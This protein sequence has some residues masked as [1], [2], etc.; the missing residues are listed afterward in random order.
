MK[1]T[2]QLV[3][4]SEAW[5]QFRLDHFGASEAAAMLSLSKNVRRNDLLRMKKTGLAKVF[6]DWVQKNVLDYGHKVEKLA[7][8]LIEKRIGQDLYPVTCSIGKI[9]ASCDGLTLDDEIA[10]E[11]KQWNEAY[12]ALI[13]AGEVPEEHMPQ[14]Q[15]ILM[16]TGA[17]K[18][19]LVMSDG[20]EEN[21]VSIE[22][23]PDPAW[24]DRLRAGWDQFEVD[25]ADYVPESPTAEPV[26]RTPESLP[27]LR[28]EVTGMVT[29]SN[30]L[31][32]KEHAFAV[33]AGINRELT[34]DQH[35]ADAAKTVKWCGDVEDRLAAAKQHALSQT[36]SI[37]ELF[38]TI[39]DISAE[40]RR[41]RLDLNKLVEAQ[42]EKRRLEILQGGQQAL[43]V[44][45]ATLNERIGKP[46]MPAIPADFAAAMKGKRTID[47]LQ[48]AVDSTLAKAKIAANAVA[49]RI[50]LNLK[51]LAAEAG[52]FLALFADIATIAQKDPQ[53]FNA[54]VQFRVAD[55]KA[56]DAKRAEAARDQIRQQERERAEQLQREAQEAEDALIRSLWANAR[57]IEQDSVPYIEKAIAAFESGARDWENDPRPRVA[58]AV[59]LAREEMRGKLDAAKVRAQAAADQATQVVQQAATTPAPAAA[60]AAAPVR[61]AP[62]QAIATAPAPAADAVPTMTLG[63]IGTR[64]G[65]PLTADFLRQLGFEPAGRARAALLFHEE[66][67]PA[68]CEALVGHIYAALEAQPA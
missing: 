30:L 9:S 1:L 20:T 48:D 50:D 51:H 49:D 61:A 43:A 60:P 8:A 10:F 40:A 53:D 11:H 67:F 19:I 68:I 54:L 26:G 5:D 42:K 24:F 46:Y 6:A 12:A 56:K 23:L 36:A 2:H 25:L 41:V 52:D 65:F 4:G 7:R 13:A 32:Y 33:F 29:S 27:A 21:M 62:P 37:D 35:F 39:D 59:A 16:V 44:H 63:Q 58:E 28:I 47:S 55:Q 14:C 15:Q 66:S 38:R 34:T 22:V 17:K 64:L 3:Q 31:A 45:I 18:L 57:R